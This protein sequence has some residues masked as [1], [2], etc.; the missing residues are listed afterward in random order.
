VPRDDPVG[1]DVAGVVREDGP[2]G[3]PFLVVETDRCRARLT[4]YGAHV[5][6]WSPAGHA[7]PVLFLSPRA[8]FAPGT[9]IRGGVPVCFPWFANH[10]S[11]PAKPAHGFAR[12]RTWQVDAVTRDGAGDPHVVFRLA[13]DAETSAYWDAAFAASLA[14]TLGPS[15]TMTLDVENRGDEDIGYEAALHTY[16][17]VGDVEQVRVHGLEGARFID[18]VDG[19]RQKVADDGPL[20]FAGEVDRVFLD[21]TTTCT[22]E[23]PGLG[24]T[25]RV[26]KRGSLVTVVWN[27]GPV[28]GPA[29]RDLGDAWRRFVCVETANCAPYRVRLAPRERHAMTA[30]IA[31]A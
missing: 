8:V 10:P 3:L 20:T 12:T 23:D 31:L 2:G 5:C 14:V 21:T 11:D 15:L 28:K 30:A 18:K 22:V 17:A 24:R 19:S 9:P 6:E 27:P 13:A 29:V 26:D 7:T 1:R 4:P 16:L 25:L